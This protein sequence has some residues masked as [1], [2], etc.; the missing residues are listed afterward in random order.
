M[1]LKMTADFLELTR[2]EVRHYVHVLGVL[3]C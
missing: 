3:E 1:I 2:L